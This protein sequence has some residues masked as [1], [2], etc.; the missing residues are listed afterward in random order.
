MIE[1]WTVNK[2]RIGQ[3]YDIHRLEQGYDLV[4]GG[5]KLDFELGLKGHSDADVL[6]HAI[7][8]ALLG[9]AGQ[10]DIGKLFPPSDDSIKGIRSLTM[11]A[12]TREILDSNGW[13]IANIDTTLVAEKPR[14]APHADKM[15]ANL[16]EVLGLS[17]D[18]I[19]IKGKTKEKLGPVGEG[20]AME[21]HAITLIF[22]K[23]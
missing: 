10:G 9:A 1:V 22:K 17:P 15:K 4:L 13:E 23:V 19:S 7:I 14:L 16:A 11:L 6:T 18:Q 5:E 8:D 3:G 12:K 20:Q 2:F 21:A